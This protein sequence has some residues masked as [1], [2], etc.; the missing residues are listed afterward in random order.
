MPNPITLPLILH[1][2]SVAR[3]NRGLL[4]L[5]PS[6]SGKSSLA[7]QM[8]GQGAALLADDRTILTRRGDAVMLSCPP[9]LSG[10]IEARG[11]GLLRAP[12]HPPSPL[13]LV[14]DLAISEPARLP[15]AREVDFLGRTFPLVGG[16]ASPHLAAALGLFLVHGREAP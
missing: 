10:M 11:I 6:G 4:I 5:G 13:A 15:E 1:A 16:A 3:E 9:Q 8:I 2:T 14:V 12:A 7:L